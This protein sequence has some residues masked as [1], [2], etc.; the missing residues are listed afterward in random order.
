[1]SVVNKLM[2]GPLSVG[3][4]DRVSCSSHVPVCPFACNMVTISL[5]HHHLTTNP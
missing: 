3:S 4:Y 5:E 1:M 2:A